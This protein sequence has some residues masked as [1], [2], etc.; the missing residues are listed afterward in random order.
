M[1]V[2]IVLS[3]DQGNVVDVGKEV[4]PDVGGAESFATVAATAAA[5]A[6][7]TRFSVVAVD[8]VGTFKLESTCDSFDS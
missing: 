6:A 2:G 8:V 5:N 7:V 4:I 1:D 3:H